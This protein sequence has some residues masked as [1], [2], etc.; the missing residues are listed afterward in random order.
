MSLK[1]IREILGHGELNEISHGLLGRYLARA[2]FRKPS[3]QIEMFRDEKAA[4]KQANRDAGIQKAIRK[5]RRPEHLK[6]FKDKEVANVVARGR[7]NPRTPQKT[8]HM[9]NVDST[10]S[11]L[12]VSKMVGDKEHE[13]I[14]HGNWWKESYP[15]IGSKFKMLVSK[16]KY[17]N[18]QSYNGDWTVKDRVDGDKVSDLKIKKQVPLFQH[19][20]SKD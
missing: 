19:I 12:H 3:G 4:R 15:P 10:H 8:E 6:Q 18:K 7:L 1:R 14:I 11:L 20:T 16:H 13:A 5:L 2:A 9:K 17:D